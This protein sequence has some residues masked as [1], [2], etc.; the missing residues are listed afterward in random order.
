MKIRNSPF[1]ALFNPGNLNTDIHEIKKIP[2]QNDD[3]SSIMYMLKPNY[4]HKRIELIFQKGNNLLDAGCGIGVWSLAA[5]SIFSK[6]V[7]SDINAERIRIAKEI[8]KIEHATNIDYY[9]GPLSELPISK[10]SFDACICFNTLSFVGSSHLDFLKKINSFV[11]KKGT[12]YIAVH[13]RGYLFWLFYQA[14]YLKSRRKFKIALKV[15]Y[16]NFCYSI[17]KKG[18]LT[19]YFTNSYMLKLAKQSGL[20]LLHSGYEGSFTKKN[21][22]PI[23]RKTFLMFPLMKEY[24]FEVL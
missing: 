20:K 2:F 10:N 8:A 12:V 14:I 6:I 3:F 7:G 18:Q 21:Q 19:S 1:L 4:L 5:T 15:F 13:M 9:T 24:V 11:S 22:I 23:F 17:T 16:K